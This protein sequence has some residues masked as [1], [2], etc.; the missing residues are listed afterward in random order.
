MDSVSHWV[1]EVHADTVMEPHDKFAKNILLRVKQL[2]DDKRL[3][4]IGT[5]ITPAADSSLIDNTLQDL[6]DL[7]VEGRQTT[8]PDL[9]QIDLT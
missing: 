1:Q 6:K 8:S 9:S 5:G 3:T 7:L 4:D 2:V